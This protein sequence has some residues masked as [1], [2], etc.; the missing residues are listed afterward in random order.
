MSLTITIDGLDELQAKLEAMGPNIQTF[1]DSSVQSTADIMVSSMQSSAPV[2]T[3]F[4]E[5]NISITAQIP[6]AAQVAS[7]AYYSVFQEFGT[8]YQSGTPFFFDN[9]YM[10]FDQFATD[11]ET[12]CQTLLA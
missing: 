4:L 9:A 10:A 5:G 11:F 1:V 12:F 2:D 6:G 3:G 8:R 7:L